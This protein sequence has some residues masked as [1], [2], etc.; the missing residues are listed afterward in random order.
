MNSATTGRTKFKRIKFTDVLATV[1]AAEKA[2]GGNT[3][4]LLDPQTL[5]EING[6]VNV[7][8]PIDLNNA[9]L[10]GLD[11]NDDKLVRATGILFSGATGGSIRNLTLQA[12]AGSI[13]S[14]SGNAAQSFIFRD[15]IVVSSNS[16]GS[17]SGFGLVFCSIVQY[18]G[19]T[20]GITYNNISRLL[21]SNMGWFGNNAG[22][23][24]KLTGTFGL[25]QKQGGFTEVN[26]TAVGFDVSSNPTVVEGVL[27][28]VVFTG[29]PTS[30]KYVDPY[31]A[32]N[33]YPGYN[34]DTKWAVTCPGLPLEGDRF[35]SSNFYLNRT[36]TAPSQSFTNTGIAYKLVGTTITTN[37]NR[38][39]DGGSSNRIVY[40]GKK[41][42]IFTVTSSVSMQ[43]GGSGTTDF[44]FFFVKYTAAGVGSIVTSSET[45]I[46]SN[47][48]FVQSFPITGTI[49]LATG[50]YV[51]LNGARIN[52][53]N[54]ALIF[55]SYNM[56]LR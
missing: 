46:D 40:D 33:S 55:N 27:E 2:A 51:E 10:Q 5:Y 25:V 49:E 44:L 56:S 19:N 7:D 32:L 28:S 18:V 24:E 47:S 22:T 54:K 6:T 31:S 29:T 17:I 52:G 30:G 20:N 53:T 45:F 3:K 36:L 8:L 21:L 34:F 14:L 48:G 37:M 4:Y 35:S 13:F 50:E 41:K 11:T 12:T 38:M 42:R 1:L 23:F 26:G 39:S 16:I 9:Y 43:V 15:A